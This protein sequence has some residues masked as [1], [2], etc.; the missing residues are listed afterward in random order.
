MYT[1]SQVVDADNKKGIGNDVIGKA[2]RAR[3][4]QNVVECEDANENTPIS[5]AASKSY[6]NSL[7]VVLNIMCC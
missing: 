6:H 7:K 5:E 3:H 2:L 4:L 1:R